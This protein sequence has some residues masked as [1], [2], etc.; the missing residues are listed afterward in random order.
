ME[1]SAYTLDIL[2]HIGYAFLFGGMFLLARQSILGWPVRFIGELG[3]LF[4][5]WQLGM[6]SIVIWG[7]IGI[8]VE[9]YGFLTWRSIAGG[10][11]TKVERDPHWRDWDC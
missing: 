10:K 7:V 9:I 3:W 5:G 2:G 11:P 1:L 8:I 4:I 6:S